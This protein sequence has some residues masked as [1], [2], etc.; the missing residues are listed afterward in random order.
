MEA[1]G[2]T[3]YNWNGNQISVLMKNQSIQMFIYDLSNPKIGGPKIVYTSPK[4]KKENPLNM[5]IAKKP[6][7]EEMAI[8]HKTI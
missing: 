7:L 8:Y 3:V 5:V 2:E 4:K 1:N 6:Y